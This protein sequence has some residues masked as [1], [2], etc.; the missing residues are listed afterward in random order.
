MM[1]IADAKEIK[2]NTKI[3]GATNNKSILILQSPLQLDCIQNSYNGY[4]PQII[5]VTLED[6]AL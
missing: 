4:K 3:I 6:V 2:E 1:E 5:A